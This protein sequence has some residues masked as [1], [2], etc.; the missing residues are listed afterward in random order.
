MDVDLPRH[1]RYGN[2][3]WVL[4]W[5]MPIASHS[6]SFIQI[7]TVVG[8]VGP[9][10]SESCGTLR[11]LLFRQQMTNFEWFWPPPCLGKPTCPRVL[12]IPIAAISSPLL[13]FLIPTLSSNPISGQMGDSPVGSGVTKWVHLIRE[14]RKKDCLNWRKKIKNRWC[15]LNLTK[16]QYDNINLTAKN[17]CRIIFDNNMI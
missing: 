4:F 15:S 11:P 13:T 5:P 6:Y 7:L 2:T 1:S 16:K 8:V 3:L 12:S 9:S 17:N 10:D 14:S